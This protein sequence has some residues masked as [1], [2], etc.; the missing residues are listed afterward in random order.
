MDNSL[1]NT[2]FKHFGVTPPPAKPE[3]TN[4]FEVRPPRV[5][6]RP[7]P[8]EAN[9]NAAVC[10]VEEDV[11]DFGYVGEY[12]SLTENRIMNYFQVILNISKL[13]KKKFEL[14]Q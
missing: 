3:K 9:D 7:D 10:A 5:Y 8:E 14:K 12:K 2:I 11:D 6:I 1:K 4:K 13:K